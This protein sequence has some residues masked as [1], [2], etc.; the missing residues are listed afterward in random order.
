[1]KAV[2]A[3]TLLLLL[4]ACAASVPVDGAQEGFVAADSDES[5]PQAPPRSG[6]GD[7]SLTAQ[8]EADAALLVNKLASTPELAA[9][10]TVIRELIALG[11]RY[12]PF[13]R[14]IG[15]E[16]VA[17]DML[18]VIHRIE[19]SGSKPPV[20][21][22]SVEK[23]ADTTGAAA[24]GGPRHPDSFTGEDFD[25]DEAEKFMETRLRQAQ[26]LLDGGRYDQAT[27]IAEAA[28]VLM[29]DSKWRREF[30]ALILRARGEGQAELLVAGTMTLGASALRY[31][32]T[33]RG[34]GFESP[35]EIRCF[36][37]NVSAQD[38]TLRLYEGK[39]KESLLQLTVRFEQTDFQGN[40]LMQT[41]NVRLPI[42][43]GGAITLAPNSSH[44]IAVPLDG[45][46]SLD[47][48][49]PLKMA[50][51]TAHIEA[52]LR[53]YGALDGEG[54]PLV[55]RPVRFASQAVRIFPHAFDL[56]TARQKPLAT[57]RQHIRDGKAQELY[58]CAHVIEQRNLRG[59][60]DLL[61]GADISQSALPVQRARLRAMHALFNVG[62]TWDVRQWQEWWSD[63]R[64]KQ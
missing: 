4:A 22:A 27:R 44:E 43:S 62:A 52:A 39:G 29:P 19:S 20:A 25:R 42:A 40:V 14:K 45:L 36:L 32:A 50:L 12:L 64:L 30:D 41:G 46:S 35:L 15:D 5:A 3:I 8:E 49:A 28:I 23:P 34:A 38:I 21:E 56:D 10:D 26:Q 58:L 54:K 60:G 24:E 7:L 55:L 47:A 53:V 6:P 2:V 1:M 9:R 13:L 59:A 31:K 17:M 51:G 57:L 37:K 16:S 18:Y 11:P 48:D 33:E 61:V 63:N